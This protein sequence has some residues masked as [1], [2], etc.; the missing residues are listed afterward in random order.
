MVRRD[1]P[2]PPPLPS[3]YLAGPDVDEDVDEALNTVA[4]DQAAR[5]MHREVLAYFESIA[6]IDFVEVPFELTASEASITFGAWGGF[7]GDNAGFSAYAYPIFDGDGRGN[8]AEIFGTTPTRSRLAKRMS[9]RA[10]SSEPLLFT[11]LVTLWA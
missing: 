5:E 8:I 2:I 4:L 3:Y 7:D 1:D 6:N 10:G 11:K 9:A